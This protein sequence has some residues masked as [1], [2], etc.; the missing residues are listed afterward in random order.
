MAADYSNISFADDGRLKLLI[1][2]GTRPEVIRLS[3]VIKKAELRLHPE[4][5]LL[6]RFVA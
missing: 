1:I 2:V 6:P 4:R 5:Y 3:E